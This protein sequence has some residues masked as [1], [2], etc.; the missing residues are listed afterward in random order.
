MQITE[1]Q[2]RRAIALAYIDAEIPVDQE[3]EIEVRGR[4][5]D[6]QLVKWE[7]RSEAPPYFRGIPVDWETI[8]DVQVTATPQEQVNLILKKSLENPHTQSRT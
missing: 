7:G 8:S 4:S 1:E 2:D 5:L 6:A 3:L